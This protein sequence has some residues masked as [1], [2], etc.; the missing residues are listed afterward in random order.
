LTI[1]TGRQHTEALQRRPART[2]VIGGTM[3]VD[4]QKLFNEE[5]P[6]NIAKNADAAKR[7]GAKIQLR[8]TGEG[9]GEWFVDVSDSGPHIIPGNP[10]GADATVTISAEDFPSYYE[11]PRGNGM[12][13]LFSGKLSIVGNQ[14]QGMR[15]AQVLALK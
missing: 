1:G 9:G 13:L 12:M 14:Q 5:L 8:I 11:S 4:L 15:L 7:I 2:N 10:G 3:A 6:A